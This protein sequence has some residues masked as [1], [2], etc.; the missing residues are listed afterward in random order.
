MFGALLAVMTG[1]LIGVAV[2]VQGMMVVM[3]MTER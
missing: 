1:C 2:H 3:P